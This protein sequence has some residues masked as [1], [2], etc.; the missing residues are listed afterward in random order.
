MGGEASVSAG[1]VGRNAAA[2]TNATFD[3]E[4]VR[5]KG[6]YDESVREAERL[7]RRHDWQVVSDTSY[8]GYEEIPRDV[9]QGYGTIADEVFEQLAEAN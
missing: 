4:I 7:A 1:P 5:I 6:N 8:E 9:M 2:S 3:A